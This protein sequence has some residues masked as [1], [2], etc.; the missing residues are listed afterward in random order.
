MRRAATDSGWR[1]SDTLAMLVVLV[2]PLLSGAW[3]FSGAARGV[4]NFSPL[5]L[6]WTAWGCVGAL[7]AACKVVLLTGDQVA[8]RS[9]DHGWRPWLGGLWTLSN[10][11]GFLLVF[12]LLAIVGWLVGQV[13]TLPTPPG[14]EEWATISFVS[15]LLFMGVERVLLVFTVFGLICRYRLGES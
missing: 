8:V 1:R 12:L 6:D 15:A 13:P 10:A 2:M 7:V 14:A 3:V 5:E 4:A 11:V 9:L